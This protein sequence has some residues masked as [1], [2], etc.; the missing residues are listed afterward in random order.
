M[1]PDLVVYYEGVNHFDRGI[2]KVLPAR[3]GGSPVVRRMKTAGDPIRGVMP[4]SA[5]ARRLERLLHA[6]AS[7][8]GTEPAKP[9]SGL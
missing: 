4:Y 8:G 1:E 7:G 9:A 2:P 3:L 6:W 5:L